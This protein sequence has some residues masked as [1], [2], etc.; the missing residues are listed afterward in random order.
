MAYIGLISDTHGYFDEKVRK[1]LEPVDVVWHAGDFG[2]EATL[3]EIATFR[4]PFCSLT[5]RYTEVLASGSVKLRERSI[6]TFR[7]CSRIAAA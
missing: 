1:F 6:P 4:S 7:Q 5:H 3:S 2:N